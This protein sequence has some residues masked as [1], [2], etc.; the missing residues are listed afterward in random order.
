MRLMKDTDETD[1]NMEA[2]TCPWRMCKTYVTN[3][4]FIWLNIHLSWDLLCFISVNFFSFSFLSF[5]LFIFYFLLLLLFFGW[6]QL[7]T[8]II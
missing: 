4:D 7:D 8:P 2:E 6:R 3:I 1:E 5:Y